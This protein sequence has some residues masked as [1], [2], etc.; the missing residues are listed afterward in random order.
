M[1]VEDPEELAAA[2]RDFVRAGAEVISAATYQLTLPGL[3]GRGFDP[4]SARRVFER[5]LQIADEVAGEEDGREVTVAASIGSYGAH[6]CDGSEYRGGF[7]VG[8]DG[9]RRF[10]DV[11]L[12]WARDAA[13]VLFETVPSADEVRAIAAL[14]RAHDR[15]VALSL[16]VGDAQRLADNTPLTE[17]LPT[18][19]RA[20]FAFVGINCVSPRLALAAGQ[21]L[22]E[23]GLASPLALYPNKGHRYEAGKG[24]ARPAVAP[25]PFPEFA[26]AAADL[27]SAYVG[28]CCQTGPSE[29][30]AARARLEA[31]AAAL[32]DG[33]AST[34]A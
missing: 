28:G 23:H 8:V 7:G 24:W 5:G 25:M 21:L 2:H 4:A 15:P 1:I 33:G 19:D 10:H 18:L 22:A 26:E 14:A 32:D 30:A 13:L 16:V 9:L 11:T 31:W 6:C 27:G 17:L 12:D 3:K 29:I 34:N 20:D